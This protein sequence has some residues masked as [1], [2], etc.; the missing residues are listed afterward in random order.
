MRL[1]SC[2]RSLNVMIDRVRYFCERCRLV[3]ISSGSCMKAG[4]LYINPDSVHVL[5][6]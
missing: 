5:S 1:R 6:Q 2:V 3:Q 4:P